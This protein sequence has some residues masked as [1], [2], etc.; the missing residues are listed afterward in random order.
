[1]TEENNKDVCECEDGPTWETS[2][3][4]DGDIRDK[5]SEVRYC[6]VCKKRIASAED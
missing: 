4:P 5:S 3:T 2:R 6:L 1:M